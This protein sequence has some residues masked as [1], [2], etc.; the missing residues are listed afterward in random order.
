MLSLL[1][2]IAVLLVLSG[3]FG[4]IN[5][6]Y[7]HLPNAVGL[8]V[9]GLAAS[10]AVAGIGVMFP[11]SSI[12]AELT[13]AL[14]QIDFTAVVLNGMLAFL[15]FA[16]ALGLDVSALRD[17]AGPV[18]LLAVMGTPHRGVRCRPWRNDAVAST[19]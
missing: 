1:D 6:R 12:V 11:G 10:L 5:H 2:L 17:R 18:A 8:L 15:L 14:R 9:M 13:A 16:G 19:V 4:W 3:L 7:F